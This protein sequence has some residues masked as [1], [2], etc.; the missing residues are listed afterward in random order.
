[1]VSRILLTGIEVTLK[2]ESYVMNTSKKVVV[3]VQKFY[4]PQKSLAE[5]WIIFSMARTLP[6]NMTV[7]HL[8]VFS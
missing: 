7:H 5:G 4:K 6:L 2:F 3:D 8:L 1:M